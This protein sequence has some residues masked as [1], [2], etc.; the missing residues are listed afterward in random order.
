MKRC[1]SCG[2][3]KPLDQFGKNRARHDGLQSECKD[4]ARVRDA[5]RY[6]KKKPVVEIDDRTAALIAAGKRKFCPGCQT[7]KVI[8]VFGRNRSKPN[9]RQDYC[10]LCQRSYTLRVAMRKLA[11]TMPTW[12]IAEKLKL[13]EGELTAKASAFGISLAFYHLPWS[14]EQENELI[15]L[16]ASGLTQRKIAA[17]LGRSLEAVNWH[18][19]K[20]RKENRIN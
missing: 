4:C 10:K 9:G 20:L 16:H 19:V 13:P 17:R 7:V 15:T 14:P 1:P 18:L 12:A 11:G 3:D 8:G 5:A 2:E 6:Q